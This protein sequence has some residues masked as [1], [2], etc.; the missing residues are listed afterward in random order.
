MKHIVF[1]VVNIFGDP[2]DDEFEESLCKINYPADL[3]VFFLKKSNDLGKDEVFRYNSHKIREPFLIN[4]NFYSEVDFLEIF[5]KAIEPSNRTKN[6]YY[7]IQSLHGSG[8]GYSHKVI[9]NNISSLYAYNYSKVPF[10]FE[11]VLQNICFSSNIEDLNFWNLK[12]KYIIISPYLTTHN[13]IKIDDLITTIINPENTYLNVF[14]EYINFCSKTYQHSSLGIESSSAFL[15]DLSKIDFLLI[16]NF[17]EALNSVIESN[18]KHNP[19]WLL[20]YFKYRKFEDTGVNVQMMDFLDFIKVI[21]EPTLTEYIRQINISINSSINGTKWI[22][23]KTNKFN[24]FNGITI[25]LPKNGHVNLNIF[26]LSFYN[27]INT[28]NHSDLTKNINKFIMLLP[29]P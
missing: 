18:S 6:K 25:F 14:N 21:D 2:K 11:F 10:N 19:A 12:T 3:E 24:I 16:S 5:S 8:F 17:F 4:R 23:K 26:Y 13:F 28:S 7:L 29:T 27:S 20:N 1:F 22:G 9:G 15:I